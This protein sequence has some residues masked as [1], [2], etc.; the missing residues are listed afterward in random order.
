MTINMPEEERLHREQDPCFPRFACCQSPR[1]FCPGDLLFLAYQSY[2]ALVCLTE[3]KRKI[4]FLLTIAMIPLSLLVLVIYVF[5]FLDSLVRVLSIS[6]IFSKSQLK[7]HGFSIVFLFSVSWFS[8]L[9]FIVSFILLNLSL[10]WSL[11]LVFRRW[12]LRLFIFFHLL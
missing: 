7:F 10:Y 3:G 1:A 8:D 9:I 11:S 12:K 6:L 2:S 4:F 5:C